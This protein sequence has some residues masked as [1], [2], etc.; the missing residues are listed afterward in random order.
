M[1]GCVEGQMDGC[2]AGWMNEWIGG[3][4]KGEIIL[5]RWVI[6]VGGWVGDYLSELENKWICG[7]V[8]RWLD[9]NKLF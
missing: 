6:H 7:C 2:V 9:G 8:D 5:G 1:D 4:T 3:W